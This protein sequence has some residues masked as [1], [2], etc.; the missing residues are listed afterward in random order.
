M[1]IN[2]AAQ[3][4]KYR[5]AYIDCDNRR[6]PKTDKFCV[7]CNRDLEPS[8]DHGLVHLVDGGPFAL[9]PEDEEIYSKSG[10]DRSDLGM[11]F[12]GL[13]CAKKIGLE[14][15]RKPRVQKERINETN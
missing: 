2:T 5:T 3:T 15:V 6:D 7:R 1:D 10:N 8:Q 12:I 14:F 13:D 4:A 11:F 9:H